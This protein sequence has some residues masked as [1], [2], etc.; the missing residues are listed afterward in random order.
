MAL[1]VFGGEWE[2]G[3]GPSPKQSQLFPAGPTIWCAGG[4]NRRD[5]R[6]LEALAAFPG[7]EL[8][9]RP[10]GTGPQVLTLEV[11][12]IRSLD[13]GADLTIEDTFGRVLFR[14]PLDGSQQI[15]LGGPFVGGSYYA[16]RLGGGPPEL[17]DD[18]WLLLSAIQWGVPGDSDHSRIPIRP[19]PVNRAVPLH[20][21]AC[22]D[23]T[24]LSLDRWM[25]LRG[26]PELD[27]YSMNIDS[28][29]CWTAH[30]GGAREE[31]LEDPMRIY[32]IEHGAGWTPEGEQKMYERVAAKGLSWLEFSDALDWARVMNRFDAPLI[33][34]LGDWGLGSEALRE[35]TP[36]AKAPES[37]P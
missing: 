24:L 7:A 13:E 37:R 3:A 29:F 36:R 26:Y 23:F 25:D 20:N 32:H 28:L 34:N 16:L 1:R 12:P 5:R 4:W 10:M 14:G 30:H 15:T 8:I 18:P 27:L 22:G 6:G 19:A 2:G 17:P 31:V 11:A 21:N 9:V 33:F 35:T